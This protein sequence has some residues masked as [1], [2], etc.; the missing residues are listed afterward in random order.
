MQTVT[1]GVDT[2]SKR[3]IR[4][5]ALRARPPL[6]FDGDAD[7]HTVNPMESKQ[8]INDVLDLPP[9][10]EV[11]TLGL[12]FARKGTLE[13]YAEAFVQAAADT[14]TDL[15]V[16]HVRGRLQSLKDML[17]EVQS[18][19][20]R[21]APIR[22]L[23]D[24]A[25]A[26]RRE[27]RHPRGSWVVWALHRNMRRMLET[28]NGADGGFRRRYVRLVSPLV[29]LVD[30]L[31]EVEAG[32]SYIVYL[33]RDPRGIDLLEHPGVVKRLERLVGGVPVTDVL[34]KHVD[35]GDLVL[36]TARGGVGF[37]SR[38]DGVWE[39]VEFPARLRGWWAA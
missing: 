27:P 8:L 12:L 5:S 16:E 33:D 35:D 11:D 17:T 37:R 23:D 1:T 10:P 14:G 30:E 7:A 36:Y 20:D 13:R 18:L 2:H 3:S 39:E 4:W 19:G 26:L 21:S 25:A 9:T 24:F 38:Q 34:V 29:P 15:D 6:P 28:V 32:G 22:T 31:P